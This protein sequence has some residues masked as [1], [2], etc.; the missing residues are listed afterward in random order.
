MNKLTKFSLSYPA[1]KINQH[2]KKIM[3]L[4]ITLYSLTFSI[5]CIWK[6]NHF[7]YNALDLAIINNVFYNTLHG[8][9]LWSSIQGHSYLGDHF[10]PILI[11]LLPIYALWQ[12]PEILLILQSIFLSLAA[13]PIYL[14]GK[15]ILKN[16]ILAL[17]L[18]VLWLI[19]PLVHNINLF[20]FHFISILPLALLTLFYL[21]LKLKKE[22]NKKLLFYFFIILFLNLMIRE[23]V[24]FIL[25]VLG[26][27]ILFDYFKNKNNFQSPISNILKL[28]ATTFGIS[29]IWILISTKLISQFSPSNFSPFSYYYQWLWQTDIIS[30]VNHLF[31]LNNFEMLAGLLL[32]FLF[33]PLFKPKWLLIAII[34]LGQIIFS[35]AGGGA[36]VW[37]MHYGALFLP[38]III[39]FIYS[40]NKANNLVNKYF[41][42]KYLLT[43]ALIII[44]IC[45][46]PSFG[47]WQNEKI[48][49]APNLELIS[50]N[51]SVIA[52]FN[53]L[54]N[55][56]SRKNIYSLHYYFLG[57]QQFGQAPYLIETDPEY[58]VYNN[59]DFEYFDKIL[60]TS[61]WAGTYYTNG[62]KRLNNLLDSYIKIEAD[63]TNMFFIKYHL[64]AQK[65]I[66]SVE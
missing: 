25:I 14:I 28:G 31:S 59:R 55:L 38:A 23:D 18:G 27:V 61:A 32:P 20:E 54:S 47:I 39:T 8:N 11:L 41:D 51:S 19:N 34:P 26:I 48:K 60:Q 49:K 62:Y 66:P 36:L 9:W 52:G 10:T 63:K 56:S 44:N 30:I 24:A 35:A 4:A 21:Y 6:Y 15:L 46:W 2:S 64:D 58:I 50:K 37:Q 65:S 16:N 17:G 7:L 45:L 13:W 42:L 22:Y 29:L 57:A 33:I 12:S 43:I 5:I 1:N 40:F 53:Y 3:W